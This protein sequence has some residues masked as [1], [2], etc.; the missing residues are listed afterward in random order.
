MVR[1][2][3]PAFETSYWLPSPLPVELV[4]P[5]AAEPTATAAATK[6]ITASRATLRFRFIPGPSDR[7][8]GFCAGRRPL[9]S[10]L[11]HGVKTLDFHQDVDRVAR[12]SAGC[13][14]TDRE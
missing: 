8:N 3:L 7:E 13:T 12:V 11:H 10:P 6:P 1:V 5:A 14:A 4:P 2:T 9:L